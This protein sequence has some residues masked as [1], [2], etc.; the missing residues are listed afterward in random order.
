MMSPPRFRP[1]VAMSHVG[2][3]EVANGSGRLEAASA[4]RPRR[5][6]SS[7]SSESEDESE[8]G[9]SRV[10]APRLDSGGLRL[11]SGGDEV[12]GTESLKA[13]EVDVEDVADEEAESVPDKVAG[14]P[15]KRDLGKP[16]SGTEDAF[17]W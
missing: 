1:T 15:E 2:E 4:S 7:S 12:G 3:E 14:D 9:A 10:N 17:D 11:W 13:E 8:T 6:S 16:S 5:R